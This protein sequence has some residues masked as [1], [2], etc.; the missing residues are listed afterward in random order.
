M[1]LFNLKLSGKM[2]IKTKKNM[3][4]KVSGYQDIKVY[5]QVAVRISRF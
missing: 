2:S 4:Q 3:Q 1:R 5:L